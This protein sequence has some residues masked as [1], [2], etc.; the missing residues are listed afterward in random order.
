MRRVGTSSAEMHRHST[1]G[2]VL[3]MGPMSPVGLREDE[4]R[5]VASMYNLCEG[6]FRGVRSLWISNVRS[7]LIAR[8]L[9]VPFDSLLDTGAQW[10]SRSR[11]IVVFRLLACIGSK[12]LLWDDTMTTTSVSR[13]PIHPTFNLLRRTWRRCMCRSSSHRADDLHLARIRCAAQLSNISY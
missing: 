12:F 6:S 11:S 13:V 7:C 3:P 1:L 4:L 10:T 5:G 8:V 2:V 9:S